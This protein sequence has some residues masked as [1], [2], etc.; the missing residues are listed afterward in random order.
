MEMDDVTSLDERR[1]PTKLTPG[2]Q[3]TKQLTIKQT[4][5]WY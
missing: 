5:F 4:K 1:D 3:Q 2:N